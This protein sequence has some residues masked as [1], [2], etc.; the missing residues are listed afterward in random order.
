LERASS[1]WEA[2]GHPGPFPRDLEPCIERALP[3]PIIRRHGLRLSGVLAWLRAQGIPCAV[4]EPDRPLR[5]CLFAQDGANFLFLDADDSAEEQRLSLAHETAHYLRDY[6]WPREQAKRRFGPDVLE[7]LDGKRQPRPEERLHG[8]LCGAHVRCRTHLLARANEGVAVGAE[9]RAERDADRLA[10]ELLAPAEVVLAEPMR[11]RVALIDR[12][13]GTYGLPRVH[14]A[15]YA[16]LLLPPVA[17]DPVVA[18]LWAV[19]ET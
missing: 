14:A 6:W 3:L 15:T 2:A 12:L 8:L 11:S 16:N 4:Q 18:Q 10:Y 9:A 19:R 17:I 7:V 5:A 13:R 1:F